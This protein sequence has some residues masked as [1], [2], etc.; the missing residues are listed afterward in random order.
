MQ[1]PIDNTE[2]SVRLCCSGLQIQGTA[3]S[4]PITALSAYHICV[5][6]ATEIGESFVKLI[7]C[8]PS[9]SQTAR[10]MAIAECQESRAQKK[11]DKSTFPIKIRLSFK[12]KRDTINRIF[13]RKYGRLSL[14]AA[15]L[16]KVYSAVHSVHAVLLV[17]NVLRTCHP[18]HFRGIS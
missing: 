15:L 8:A 11:K 5:K 3:N 10:K 14:R 13:R 6:N 4:P 17:C 2:K 9:A 12:G 16:V 18:A 7:F 1:P